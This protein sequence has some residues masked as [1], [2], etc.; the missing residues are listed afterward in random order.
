VRRE[1]TGLVEDVRSFVRMVREHGARWC[2]LEMRFG[3]EG[4]EALVLEPP[5]WLQNEGL[6]VQDSGGG[7]GTGLSSSSS[8]CAAKSHLQQQQ[9]HEPL[10]AP[11]Q[12]LPPR[13]HSPE[14]ELPQHPHLTREATRVA[15]SL[16][17]PQHTLVVVLV[18]G[19]GLASAVWLPNVELIFGLTG[20]TASVLAAFIMPAI[21]FLR[22]YEMAPE[23]GSGGRRHHYAPL[24]GSSSGNAFWRALQYLLTCCN[25]CGLG[26]WLPGS[27][28]G[29]SYASFGG[30]P[31]AG[32]RQH[33]SSDPSWQAPASSGGGGHKVWGP[34][35]VVPELRA[36]W[37]CRQRLALL[38]LLFGLISGLLCT[39]AILSS[40]SEEKAVVQL[41]QVR[42]VWWALLCCAECMRCT[43]L[44]SDPGLNH[45]PGCSVRR[46]WWR[47]R[48]WWLRPAEPSR[49][50][51]K[52]QQQWTRSAQQHSSWAQSTAAQTRR[53]GRWQLQQR[54]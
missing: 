35:L 54:P 42:V 22:L 26:S 17:G 39:D 14:D 25:C 18:L 32:A 47:T 2:R 5:R 30:R 41:A 8:S 24:G 37:A 4:A 16:T 29:S 43:Q 38:L 50:P 1:I 51:R 36:Q 15:N 44:L 20:S 48:L 19:V 23:L 31:G 10:L 45:L 27:G 40:I 52:R 7:G 34:V 13:T 46:S 53:W 6:L 11:A 28:G 12:V 3:M 21:C 9:E 33:R 49:K